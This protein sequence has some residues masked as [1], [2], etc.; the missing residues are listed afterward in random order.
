MLVDLAGRPLVSQESRAHGEQVDALE[1]PN[2]AIVSKRFSMA[3]HERIKNDTVLRERLETAQR[4][5]GRKILH[6]S[7]LD[8]NNKNVTAEVES[9]I[10]KNL[11]FGEKIQRDR[12]KTEKLPESEKAYENLKID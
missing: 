4:M 10:E 11:D 9:A 12:I 1:L 6:L 8:R 3:F 7:L 5:T 2:G